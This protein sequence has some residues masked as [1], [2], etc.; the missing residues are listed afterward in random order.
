MRPPARRDPPT[1]VSR[2]VVAAALAFAA[3][4]VLPSL[5]RGAAPA[6]RAPAAAE[7]RSAPLGP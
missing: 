7:G 6:S 2:T 5:S 1:R 3:A 4:L